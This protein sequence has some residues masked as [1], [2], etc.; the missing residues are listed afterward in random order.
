MKNQNK[1]IVE[2]IIIFLSILLAL[3]AWRFI[4][5]PYEK[6]DII[7]EYSDQSYN[8][9]TDVLRYFSFIAFPTFIFL[10]LKLINNKGS[11]KL[12][13][14]NLIKQNLEN[15]SNL[16]LKICLAIFLLL[17]TAEFF[18]INYEIF[19]IDAY[20]DGQ[21]LSSAYKSFID[22]S[23]WSGSYVTVG[24]FYETL[25]SKVSWLFLDKVSIGSSKIIELF[26]IF[27]TKLILLSVAYQISNYSK[28]N[29]IS[30][31]FLFIILSLVF[32]SLND[33]DLGSV[34]QL[35][36]REIPILLFVIFFPYI[37]KKNLFS[38]I[39][40]FS[41]GFLF[42]PVLFWGLDRGIIFIFILLIFLIYFIINNQIKLTISLV[43]S[44]IFSYFFFMNIL[45]N[46]FNHFVSNSI[47][48]IKEI[49]YI[50]GIIHPNPLTDDQNSARA[51][52]TLLIIIISFLISLNL[53]FDKSEKN[54]LLQKMFLLISICCLLC[55]INALGR[56]DG[57]HIRS[58]IGFPIMFLSAYT[59]FKFLNFLEKKLLLNLDIKNIKIF[60]LIVSSFFISIFYLDISFKNISDFNERIDKFINI[61][62]DKFLN[63]KKFQTVFEIKQIIEKENCIQLFTNAAIMPYLL[64]K[65]NCTKY[66]FV[67]SL[68]S[69]EMQKK[70]INDIQN[71][72]F[73]LSDKI[74][75]YQPLSPNKKLPI[76]KNF[77]DNN[78]FVF[79]SFKSF[80]LLKKIE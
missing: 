10:T 45:G 15:N 78:Y 29:K 70:M 20:H 44:L 52:K 77:I 42:L 19:M 31:L 9:L 61:E 26:L 23:L 11:I 62:D 13:I 59:I 27:I 33:Y 63:K 53:F 18:S 71:V 58:T 76:V 55:Y 65:K 73:I 12:F 47:N 75:D 35:G 79:K 68:G 32:L 17:C 4:S 74:N 16:F 57:P 72:K 64:K 3:Y 6:V 69:H 50:H 8:A 49:N 80:D 34:D 5:L 51:T 66:Y 24:I 48:I 54:N 7:G 67:W 43:I 1:L 22:G 2:S 39:I 36:Y 56:S 14:G 46:E 25:M 21:K 37:E 30:Q 40:V 60:T 41:L 28:L 38:Y